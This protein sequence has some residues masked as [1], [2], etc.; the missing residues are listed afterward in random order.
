MAITLLLQHTTAI[1]HFVCFP[2]ILQLS[3]PDRP[4]DMFYLRYISM[5]FDKIHK[6]QTMIYSRKVFFLFKL[7][8]L[9]LIAS[10]YLVEDPWRRP[11]RNTRFALWMCMHSGEHPCS[12]S[13][14]PDPAASASW[15]PVTHAGTHT[16]ITTPG[17]NVLFK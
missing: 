1:S 12:R 5:E 7:Y 6:P 17:A 16:L 13:P 4:S 15:C 10:L 8:C 9:S 14:A 11:W 2:N 3:Y